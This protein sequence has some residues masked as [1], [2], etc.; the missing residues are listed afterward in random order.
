MYFLLCW[1]GEI[2]AIIV[3]KSHVSSTQ[4]KSEVK[5]QIRI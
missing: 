5:I 3:V 1:M 4:I 2:V